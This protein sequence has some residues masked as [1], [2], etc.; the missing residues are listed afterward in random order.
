MSQQRL[1]RTSQWIERILLLGM[2][3]TPLMTLLTQLDFPARLA[4]ALAPFALPEAEQASYQSA[5]TS[6]PRFLF[7]LT[8]L[9]ADAILMMALWQLYRLCRGYRQL[10]LFSDAQILRYRRL[11]F[12]IC[13]L[14]V[15][16]LL[17]PPLQEIALTAWGPEVHFTLNLAS[18]DFRVLLVGIAVQALAL[19]MGE[20]KRLA[21][22]QALTV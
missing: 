5:L 18:S 19:V 8:C 15:G 3:C 10:E 4:E 16:D 20:A 12:W 11:G 1:I 7:A 17:L 22:D 13:M 9:G 2:I 21:D 14:F 6:L